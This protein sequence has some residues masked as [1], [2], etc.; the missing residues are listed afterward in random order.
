MSRKTLAESKSLSRRGDRRP[1][2]ST[3]RP[4]AARIADEIGPQAS[5]INRRRNGTYIGDNETVAVE[6][7]TELEPVL[8]LPVAASKDLLLRGE[9]SDL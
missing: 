3:V 7:E 4:S 6:A 5:S 2:Q 1:R 8:R 9:M